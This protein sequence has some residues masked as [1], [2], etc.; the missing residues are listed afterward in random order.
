MSNH[1][2]INSYWTGSGFRE[3]PEQSVSSLL[4]DPSYSQKEKDRHVTTP[5]PETQTLET[6]SARRNP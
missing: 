2:S 4:V 3:N 6:L 5:K 1:L